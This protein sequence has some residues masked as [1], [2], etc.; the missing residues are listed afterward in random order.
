MSDQVYDNA[1]SW[2]TAVIAKELDK[3]EYQLNEQQRLNMI[4]H[5]DTVLDLGLTIGLTAILVSA[6]WL[7][8]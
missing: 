2:A 1:V 4:R 3:G 8:S 7:F 6:V 5:N